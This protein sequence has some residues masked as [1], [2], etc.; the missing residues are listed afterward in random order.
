MSDVRLIVNEFDLAAMGD[1]WETLVSAGQTIAEAHDRNRWTLGDLGNKV[2]R[3]YGT[4]ALGSYAFQINVRQ[5]TMYE[6]A[7]CSSFYLFDDRTA[8]PPL[9]WSHYRAAMKVKDKDRET[10]MLWLAK[11]ADEGWTV[12]E[13]AE[14]INPKGPRPEKLVELPATYVM[15]RDVIDPKT[16]AVTGHD[17]VLRLPP[18]MRDEL[19]VL[20]RGE[21]Y[22][23]KL[24]SIPET[25]D[26]GQVVEAQRHD[27]T[28]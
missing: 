14:A 13:L 26:D 28:P 25:S 11:A 17:V 12:E 4:N 18:I 7:A 6:Y 15:S 9:S 3:R 2:T 10:A 21:V 8:F 16:G 20:E 19:A 23:L 22:T 5:S 27:H 24:Y 1:E